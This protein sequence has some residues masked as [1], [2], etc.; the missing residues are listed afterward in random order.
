MNNLYFR[1]IFKP[2]PMSATGLNAGM[3]DRIAH[4]T[5]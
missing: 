4:I 1:N 3:S 2:I 5:A